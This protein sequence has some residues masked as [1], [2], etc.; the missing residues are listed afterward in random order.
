MLKMISLS[1]MKRSVFKLPVRLSSD[2]RRRVDSD[3][4]LKNDIK[5]LGKI[6][7]A[8]IKADDERVY[9]A[10]EKNRNLA[11]EVSTVLV[12]PLSYVTVRPL[13]VGLSL[14]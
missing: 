6:L 14:S 10:V 7:G 3:K 13:I 2:V 5:Y 9:Q 4:R 12:L 8:A 11:R 1:L